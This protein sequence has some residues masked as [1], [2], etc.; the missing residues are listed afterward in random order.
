MCAQRL[1]EPLCH[2][3]VPWIVRDL[4]FT[5]D[6]KSS[7]LIYHKSFLTYKEKVMRPL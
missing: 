2:C 7:R 5:G 4:K 6:Y 3:G 1:T